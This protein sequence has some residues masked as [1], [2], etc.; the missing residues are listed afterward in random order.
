MF[1]CASTPSKKFSKEPSL[2]FQK[3]AKK[4]LQEKSLVNTS[5][6]YAC[7]LLKRI[8][9]TDFLSREASAFCGRKIEIL[10]QSTNETA[11]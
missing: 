10:P 3:L 11:K 5:I 9:A 2:K 1:R 4:V 7:N 6:P 8:S